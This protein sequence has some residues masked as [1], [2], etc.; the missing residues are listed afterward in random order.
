MGSASGA[1]KTIFLQSDT[2]ELCYRIGLLLQE[3]QAG[4]ISGIVNDDLIA[5]VYK[6]IKY[7]CM[8]IKQLKQV[9]IKCNLLHTKKN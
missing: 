6:K 7:E 2:N 3:K 5:L 4:N 9:S 1:S 8:S